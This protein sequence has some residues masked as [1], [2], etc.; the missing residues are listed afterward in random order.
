M[1]VLFLHWTHQFRDKTFRTQCHYIKK[2]ED[3]RFGST[4]KF[5]RLCSLK[6]IQHNGD[7]SFQTLVI[8]S[9]LSMRLACI[10][11]SEAGRVWGDHGVLSWHGFIYFGTLRNMIWQVKFLIAWQSRT[12]LFFFYQNQR[13]FI[14]NNN[15][16]FNIHQNISIYSNN[17][18]R[19]IVHNAP[20]NSNCN[21]TQPE[22]SNKC[23]LN[24]C[25]KQINGLREFPHKCR[26]RDHLAALHHCDWHLGLVACYC[27]INTNLPIKIM[28]RAEWGVNMLETGLF[29]WHMLWIEYTILWI[30]NAMTSFWVIYIY[31]E[32]QCWIGNDPCLP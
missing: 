16:V 2:H 7:W 18:R 28:Q 10:L 29:M 9:D 12:P 17:F 31:D 27:Y 22:K 25:Y 30:D 8:F 20:F 21:G 5:I 15:V 19:N 4:V 3:I 14:L 13:S 23:Q 24:G 11:K 26:L 32:C 1:Q 6:S